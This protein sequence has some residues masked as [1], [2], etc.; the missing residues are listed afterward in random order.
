MITDA[1][2]HSRLSMIHINHDFSAAGRICWWEDDSRIIPAV[3]RDG[4]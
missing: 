1:A 3:Q 2:I 4:V